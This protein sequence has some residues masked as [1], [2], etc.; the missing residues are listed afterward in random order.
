MTTQDHEPTIPGER[1]VTQFTPEQQGWF[2]VAL[3]AFLGV[4]VVG[5]AIT[6]AAVS[7]R[8]AGKRATKKMRRL[9]GGAVDRVSA[10]IDRFRR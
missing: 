10:G 6:S 9:G 4:V 8:A 3:V 7:S 1:L 2:V 5:P